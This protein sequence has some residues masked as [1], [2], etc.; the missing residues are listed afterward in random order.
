MSISS[1]PPAL[2]ADSKEFWEAAREQRLLIKRCDACSRPFF[3][4]RYL[5]PFCWSDQTSWLESKGEGT[6]Y[7]YTVMQRAPAPEFAARVPY[8]VALVD[9]AEG[10]RVLANV[11][12][13]GALDTAVGDRV[14]VCFEDRG[15][16]W[17]VP[18][19]QRSG[20]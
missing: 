9:L 15:D 12:G 17:K 4:P 1:P 20:G 14:R 2:N 5:C 3:P 11:I 16:G 6:V 8:V 13:S 18:Q 19:F 7:S 10:P